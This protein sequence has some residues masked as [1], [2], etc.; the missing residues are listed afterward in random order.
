LTGDADD[1]YAILA[2]TRIA[3]LHSH[4][5]ATESERNAT[6]EFT[7]MLAHETFI[8]YISKFVNVNLF[9]TA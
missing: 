9:K 4:R 3:R 7:N 2:D 1:V 8:A 6:G 5:L